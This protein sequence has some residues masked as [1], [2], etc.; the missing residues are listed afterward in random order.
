MG[1]LGRFQFSNSY[2]SRVSAI[3]CPNHP[4]LCYIYYEN[5]SDFSSAI[6]E[7]LNDAHLKHKK[8]LDSLLTLR[9]QKFNKSQIMNV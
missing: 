6:Y 4:D 3:D 9:F 8:E 7:C 2:R 1:C 5:F